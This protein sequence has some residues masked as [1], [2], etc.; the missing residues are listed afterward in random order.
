MAAPNGMLL[1]RR[2]E[3]AGAPTKR[4]DVIDRGGILRGAIRMS[5]EQTIIGTSSAGLYIGERDDVDLLT[6]SRHPWPS[7]IGD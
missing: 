5:H 6:L 3:M 1:V 4:Y 2:T 7:Q